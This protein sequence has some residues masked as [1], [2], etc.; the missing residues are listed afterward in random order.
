MEE[1]RDC[2]GRLACIAEPETGYV[3]TIYKGQKAGIILPIGATFLVERDGVHTT[4]TRNTRETITT[5]SI[6]LI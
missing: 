4:V 6:Y 1:I 2:R 5:N 3:E